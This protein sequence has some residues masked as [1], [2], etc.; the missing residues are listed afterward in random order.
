VDKERLLKLVQEKA[1]RDLETLEEAQR[2]TAMGATH[3]ENKAESDKDTR[4]TEASYLARGQANRVRDLREGVALL[5]AL[6]LVPHTDE[7]PVRVGSLL[8]LEENGV[9]Q[10]CFLLPAS[11]GGDFTLN[12]CLVRTLSTRSP[13]GRVLLGRHLEEE[14][15]APTPQGAREL[16][17]TGLW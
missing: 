7:S 5:H 4:A 17:I 13:L 3:E 15:E 10:L 8:E 2:A 1:R 6:R 11:A 14:L 16:R 9:R 12:D